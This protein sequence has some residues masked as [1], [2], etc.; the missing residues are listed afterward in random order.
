[1]G[2]FEITKEH[3][4]TSRKENELRQRVI[5]T[6]ELDEGR[7]AFVYDDATGKRITSAEEATGNPTAGVGYKLRE[8]DEHLYG[9]DLDD[10]W[11]NQKRD[12]TVKEAID[13]ARHIGKKH[14]KPFDFDKLP[15][16]QQEALVNLVFNVGIGELSTWKNTLDYIA[17]G[18]YKEA[19]KEILRG[20]T[21]DSVSK[22]ATSLPNRSKRVAKLLST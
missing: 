9:L 13:Y 2:A 6:L 14:R 17:E 5:K 7:K 15:V 18:N 22:Y 8:G 12:E 20:R 21:K 16:N 10:N 19:G 3:V 4:E 11:I 1:M